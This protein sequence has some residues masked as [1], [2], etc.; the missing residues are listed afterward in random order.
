MTHETQSIDPHEVAVRHKA[1][2]M[3]EKGANAESTGLMRDA[4]IYYQQALRIHQDVEKLYRQKIHDESQLNKMSLL[5]IDD[6]T[7][8]DDDDATD[9][10]YEDEVSPCHLLDILTDDILI[11]V[12]SILS[13][14][15]PRA[16]VSFSSTCSRISRLAFSSIVYRQICH[17]V[18]P[19]QVYSS[20]SIQLN[21]ITKDQDQMVANWDFQWSS[22]LNDRPFIKFKGCYI[23]RVTYISDGQRT[24]SFYAPVKLVTYFRYLR[25]YP[26]G[27]AIKLTTTD[28][29]D[30]IIPNFNKDNIN[31]FKMGLKTRWTLEL[32]GLV[33][34]IRH[35]SDYDFIEELKII[36]LGDRKYHRLTWVSSGTISKEGER[37][38][39]NMRKEK[40]F[41]F[42]SVKSYIV[43]T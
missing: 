21:N 41:N 26:D 18:Y 20:S 32:D 28:E 9:Q 15:D 25:F 13:Y 10:E 35:T 8:A 3:Y 22:M 30:L 11:E 2:E 17:Q 5:K 39:Y 42:S 16:H 29:P 36:S 24:I 6:D 19:Y 38:Y 27:T 34:L 1:L 7:Q 23:S 4:I 37:N 33:T 12:C 31:N 14:T 43:H 40:P